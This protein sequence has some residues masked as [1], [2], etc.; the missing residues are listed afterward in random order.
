MRHTLEKSEILRGKTQFDAVFNRGT[1][2]EGKLVRGLLILDASLGRSQNASYVVGFAV[3][4]TV[5]RAVD[6]NKLKRFLREAYR[7]NKSIL[8][9]ATNEFRTPRA[10]IFLYKS[11]AKHG[12]EL[13]SLEEI[14]ND[15]KEILEEIAEIRPKR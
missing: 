12:V 15:M 4:R 13:P 3:A 1:K 8:S 14:E 7:R 10:V 9:P 2:I 6:R 11:R 5:Q